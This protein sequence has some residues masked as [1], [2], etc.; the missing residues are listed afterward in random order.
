MIISFYTEFKLYIHF[1]LFNNI[2]PNVLLIF[3]SD[4]LGRQELDTNTNLFLN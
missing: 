4:K 1:K 3:V 2:K